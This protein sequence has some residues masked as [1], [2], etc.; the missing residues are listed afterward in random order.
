MKTI[1]VCGDPTLDWLWVK[2]PDMGGVYFWLSQQ[3]VPKISLSSQAGGSVLM[4]GLIRHMVG[5]KAEVQCAALDERYLKEPICEVITDSWTTWQGYEVKER[6]KP[7][8]RISEWSGYEPGQWDYEKNRLAGDADL[9]MIED[10][11]LGFRACEK[12]WPAA[13]SGG[14]RKPEHIILKLSKYNAPNT[15]NQLVKRIHDLGLGKSTTI[16]TAINDLRACSVR[17]GPSLS[18]EKL[19]DEIVDAVYDVKSIFC[20]DKGKLLYDRVIVTVGTS[21]AVIITSEGNALIFDRS[22][23]EDDFEHKHEG[24][25]MGYNTCLMGALAVKW[26]ENPVGDW[27]EAVRD[28]IALARFLKVE[29][30]S[31]AKDNNR[32][33][34]QFP[35][36]EIAGAYADKHSGR[37]HKDPDKVWDL[38]LYRD[39]RAGKRDT[40]D[41]DRWSILE[42]TVKNGCEQGKY[43]YKGNVGAV[44]DCAKTVVLQGPKSVLDDVPIETVGAWTSADRQEI[45]GIRSVNNAFRYYLS[46]GGKQGTPLCIAVFGPP[47]SGKSFAIKEIAKGLGIDSSSQ[48]TFNLSQFE[49]SEELTA[50]FHQIRD[51]QLKGKIPL[52]FWDEFDTRYQGKPLGWLRYFL[53][54]MQDG[55]FMENGRTHPIGRGIFIF[56]GATSHSFAKFCEG[57][58]EE[59]RAAK[60]PDFIS[61]LKAYLDIK[62]PNGNPNTIEDKLFVIRRAFLLNYFLK[63]FAPKLQENKKIQ[64]EDGVLTAFLRIGEYKHGARSM[65]TL[66]RMSA[67]GN[68]RK[69]EYSC[70][71]PDQITGMHVNIREFLDLTRY[72]HM[73]MMRIGITGHIGL[74][75]G[76]MAVIENTVRAAIAFIKEK[77]PDRYLTVFSPLSLGADRLVAR[78]LLE[79]EGSVLITVLPVPVDDYINDFGNTDEHSASYREAELR[80]EFRYWLA[81]RAIEVIELPPTPT[82]D[83]AYLQAGYFITSHCDL[84][85]AVWDGKGAAGKGGTGDIVEQAGVLGKPVVH[86][87]AGNFKADEAKRTDVGDKLGTFRYKNIPGSTDSW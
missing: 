53:A 37:P 47:G 33:F 82:R 52:I 3:S 5:G 77:F 14:G 40:S 34:L 78:L 44:C 48:I 35:F 19:F 27:T 10:S 84:L 17:I 83:D 36:K 4:S 61:R 57:A 56:A 29:G 13:L 66:I 75:P 85:I 67:I 15:V 2:N 59:D 68:K 63:T 65:E 11:G 50:A 12:G 60:K 74:N 21:G 58:S 86:V 54:P 39:L 62:G 51:L 38:G 18:W 64:I 22:G 41:R 43:G 32:L 49:S 16:V 20:D 26:L 69:Y 31:V 6:D 7:S 72:G 81:N 73:E 79:K 24:Q 42:E 8:F 30:Y 70:L 28:G 25:L 1:Q 76:H 45:E 23:Q 71:P 87:W 55:E 46:D 9:L 80:Q